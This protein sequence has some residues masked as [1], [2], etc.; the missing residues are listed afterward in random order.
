MKWTDG[1]TYM[2]TWEDGIQDGVGVMIFPDDTRRAGTFEQNVFKESL[3]RE[4]QIEPYRE[5]L[6]EECLQ[7]LEEIL[8]QK[9]TNKA[10]MFAP[11]EQN[12][13]E[14]DDQGIPKLDPEA[15]Q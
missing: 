10:N 11:A 4:D 13:K 6:K 3:K 2:G 5:I 15:S 8:N 14:L 12:L 7:V 9:I 1:S